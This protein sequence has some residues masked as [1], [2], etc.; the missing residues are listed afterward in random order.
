M[1]T[2]ILLARS[3]VFLLPLAYAAAL[4]AEAP[5]TEP[6]SRATAVAGRPLVGAIRWDAWHGDQGSPGKAVE[7]SLGPRAWHYR[8]PFFGTI[9]SDSTVQIAGYSQTIMDQE[10][11]YAKQGGLDYWAFLLYSPHDPMSQALEFYLKSGHKRDVNFCAI[12]NLP[13]PGEKQDRLQGAR[14]VK[15]MQEPGYQK[16]LRDRPLLYIYL[17]Y[18]ASASTARNATSIRPFLDSFRQ[19]AKRAGL[20]NPYIVIMCPI[21][22]TAK[23]VA[24]ALGCD[25]ISA[26]ATSGQARATPYALLAQHAEG[27]WEQCRATG[28]KVVPIV[29]AGWDRR[30]R[31]E[32][33]VPWEPYQ[34]PGVGM[35][36]YYQ[37]A[38]PREIRAHMESALCWVQ[39]NPEAADSRA[40][41]IYAWN[42]NDEGGWLVPTL[43]EGTA[44][45]DA[46][47]GVLHPSGNVR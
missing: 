14:I 13:F 40:I 3:V 20:G 33:P 6:P 47:R 43:S 17:P 19:A 5:P 27:F 41:I 21:P 16:V 18:S 2:P 9:V 7:R 34:K 44:R 42:E 45:L 39:H 22:G 8:V 46:L 11:A 28:A 30:P 12:S 37:T 29:M 25:A 38:T 35:D 32:H 24:D 10:I 23:T 15:L 36:R 26:Y 1:H 31:I 4:R